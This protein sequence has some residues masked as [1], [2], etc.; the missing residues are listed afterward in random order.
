M[1]D[2]SLLFTL[3]IAGCEATADMVVMSV[4]IESSSINKQLMSMRKTIKPSF[5]RQEDFTNK[6]WRIGW[7]C[8]LD[9]KE[10]CVEDSDRVFM[11]QR[12]LI[13]E[14][15]VAERVYHR[16]C[17]NAL[18]VHL[19]SLDFP[20]DARTMEDIRA[21]EAFVRCFEKHLLVMSRLIHEENRMMLKE[22]QELQKQYGKLLD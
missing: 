8:Y 7:N 10:K 13:R 17:V 6:L 18:P 19:R 1:W 3:T 11:K 4:T 21:G 20:K 9:G 12:A 5:D 14:E 2:E 16:T 15:K 22:L